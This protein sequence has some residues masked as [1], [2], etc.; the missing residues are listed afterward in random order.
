MLGL[1]TETKSSWWPLTSLLLIW[2]AD[3][4]NEALLNIHWFT[5]LFFTIIDISTV[6][7]YPLCLCLHLQQNTHPPSQRDQ[8][9]ISAANWVLTFQKE[10]KSS[11]WHALACKRRGEHVLNSLRL[12]FLCNERE[13]RLM[14]YPQIHPV[15]FL[16]NQQWNASILPRQRRE[17]SGIKFLHVAKQT[18]AAFW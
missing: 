10:R 15:S 4:K 6:M 5:F 9:G 14:K 2:L 11:P 8:P 13:G 3:L 16:L 17:N 12:N 18:W 7:V 1:Q